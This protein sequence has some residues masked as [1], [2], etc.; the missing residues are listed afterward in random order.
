MAIY[1]ALV[2][3]RWTDSVPRDYMSHTVYFD[4]ATAN[5]ADLEELA[6]DVKNAFNAIPFY[7]AGRGYD[8]RIYDMGQAKPRQILAQEV[9]TPA[10]AQA[11]LGNRDVALCISFFA[12]RNLPRSRGRLY[13]GP[14]VAGTAGMYRPST[15][16]RDDAGTLAPALAAAGGDQFHWGVYSRLD[17]V[18]RTVTDWY[19]DDEWDT[20]RRRGLKA[21]ARTAGTVTA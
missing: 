16:V 12:G 1:R 17:N 13:L 14:F 8:V 11:G 4:A 19:V 20:Q 6:T 15:G 2:G 10:G 9:T 3:M 18:C 7:G 5:T 21:T